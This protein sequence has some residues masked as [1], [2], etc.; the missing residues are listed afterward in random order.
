MIGN[1][2][3]KFNA[4]WSEESYQRML[5]IISDRFNHTP[6]FRI[7]ETPVFIN[8]EFEAK[9]LAA[10][11][12]VVG[13]IA[14]PEFAKLDFS[15]I[16]SMLVPGD[17]PHPM[18]LVVDFGVCESEDGSLVP[19]LI[20][21]QGFPSLFYYQ[22]LL[23][24]AFKTTYPF[25][26][27]YRH[28]FG[29]NQD[30]YLRL[31]NGLLLGSHKPENVVL[32]DYDPLNQATAIDFFC[33]QAATGIKPLCISKVKRSGRQL[34]YLDDAGNKI[35]IHRIYNRLIFDELDQHPELRLEFS[36]REE[37][38]VEWAGHPN[39]YF[40]V[41]KFILP[42]LKS[43]CVPPSQF[44]SELKSTPDDLENY[45]LKPLFSFAGSGVVF[46]VTP[47]DIA[48]VTQPEYYLLQRK[49]KYASFLQA[50]DGQ[51]KSEIRLLYVWEDGQPRPRLVHN[52]SRLSKGQLIGV[53]FNKNKAWVGG[54]ICFF[55]P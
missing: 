1:L 14:S 40:K 11:E 6:K 25:L 31:M 18:F 32:I 36:L 38:D 24:E 8:R 47:E 7:A 5:G 2:R 55:E 21:I 28:L 35:D 13:E 27:D 41:S 42:F 46:D 49:E 44:L 43:S 22:L 30:D 48:K 3:Q 51:V 17:A 10:G 39:W 12:S 33:T 9:L 45:V 54:S 19:K 20:E 26:A 29:L 16:Q 50:P 53:K 23:A 34:Y 15:P 52:L 4:A 37:V